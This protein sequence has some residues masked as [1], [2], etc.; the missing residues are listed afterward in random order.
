MSGWDEYIR[1]WRF[2]PLV[3]SRGEVTQP[4][5]EAFAQKGSLPCVAAGR[6]TGLPDTPIPVDQRSQHR[7]GRS[8]RGEPGLDRLPYPWSGNHRKGSGAG[9]NLLPEELVN[10]SRISRNRLL[11]EQPSGRI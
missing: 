6:R 2:S 11:S 7:R 4:H 10:I 5:V 3:R 8:G 1:A 9:R